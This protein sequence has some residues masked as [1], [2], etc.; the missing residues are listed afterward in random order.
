MA[1]ALTTT[2]I[3]KR[4]VTT[5]LLSGGVLAAGML[6]GCGG[7]A[8]MMPDEF[9]AREAGN[10]ETIELDRPLRE[11][12][13]SF[14]DRAPACIQDVQTTSITGPAN[15]MLTSLWRYH[16]TVIATDRQVEL[17]V[18]AMTPQYGRFE[19]PDQHGIYVMDARA[20][21]VDGRR[22]RLEIYGSW[23]PVFE[24]STLKI[25]IRGWAAGTFAGCPQL[26]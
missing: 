20:V 7:R 16:E 11:V 22:S 15:R 5:L 19:L 8:A 26:P 25:A 24:N 9:R 14:R 23:A 17:V 4:A 2:T 6:A 10:V 13:A 1:I 21:A 3:S 12:A 18:Q